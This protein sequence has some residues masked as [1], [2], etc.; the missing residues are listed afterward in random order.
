MFLQQG[1]DTVFDGFLVVLFERHAADEDVEFF[2][3]DNLCRRL[4]KLFLREVD[5]EVGHAEHGIAL[6]LAEDDLDDGTVLFHHD[7]V[8]R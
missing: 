3:L 7:T 8:Q 2:A 4:F 6:L 1:E 5:E